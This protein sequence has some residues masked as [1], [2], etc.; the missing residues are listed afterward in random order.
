MP[1][2]SSKTLKNETPCLVLLTALILFL[3]KDIILGGHSLG[4]RDF[5]S[6]YLPMKQFLYDEMH[7]H[8]SIPFWNPYLFGGM[9][10]WAHFESTIFYPLGIL[11]WLLPPVRAYGYT[12]FI[13]LVLAG[14]FM[15]VLARSLGIGR[16]GGLIAGMVFSCNGFIIATLYLGHL[17]PVMSYIW[18]PLVIYHLHRALSAGN[19]YLHAALAG[20]CWGMQILAGAPQDAFYTFCTA[21]FFLFFHIRVKPMNKRPWKAWVLMAGLFSLTGTGIASIQIFPAYELV[22]ESVRA[23]MD[24]FAMVTARSYPPEGIITTVLPRFFGDFAKEDFWVANVPF[25]VPQLTL[26]VGILPLVLLLFISPLDR[27]D[28]RQ[29]LFAAI[30]ALVAFLLALGRHNPLYQFVSILP[31]FDKFRSPAKILVIWVFSLAILAGKGMDGFFRFRPAFFGKRA[32][33]LSLFALAVTTSDFLLHFREDLTFKAFSP[34]IP[35]AAIHA[36]LGHAS[37]LIRQE[38]HRFTLLFLSIAV[39]VLF[40]ARPYIGPGIGASLLCLTLIADLCLVYRGAIPSYDEVYAS[41][42]RMK[43]GLSSALRQ[44]QEI[45]RVGTYRISYGPNI[46]M[47]LGYQGVG[48]FTELFLHRY[49]E[50]MNE[51]SDRLLPQGWV[52]LAYGSHRNR[53]FID[54]LNVKYEISHLSGTYSPRSTCLPRV[55]LVGNHK[56]LPREEILSFMK[57]PDFDPT[58]MVLFEEEDAPP[59][60][61]ARTYSKPPD[62]GKATILS[63]RPDHILMEV[64]AR[65]PSYL[66]LSEIY[67]PGWKAFVDGK[68]SDLL[69]G[70]YLFRV[71]ELDQGKHLVHI[72][73][74]PF[75]IKCGIAI[76]IITFSLFLG[77][78]IYHIWK[79]PRGEWERHKVRGSRFKA[80]TENDPFQE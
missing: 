55:F 62:K 75:S 34:F 2:L 79:R 56:V 72:V 51:G 40:R 12:M 13:H 66:F 1:T 48:G 27:E 77:A 58:A 52:N 32:V 44:D 60:L 33:L 47:V 76:T 15:Y 17:S 9:P 8:H 3:F 70:N 35:A 38:W 6:F 7:H 67:Y 10:F 25:T 64:E 53:V 71:L 26:Y 19:F 39:I 24:S 61:R 30:L 74:D 41:I 29:V 46:D 45:Y 31:G 36:Q 69:R 57:G 23:F 59:D 50:Y 80:K 22:E 28:R 63:Y 18:L 78:L 21:L 16:A 20:V 43:Q 11:F 14:I 4:G 65:A 37:E 49:Y 54:L 73:F 5:V 42:A 68:P